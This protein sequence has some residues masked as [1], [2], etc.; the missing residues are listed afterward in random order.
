MKKK[1]IYLLFLFLSLVIFGLNNTLQA[2]T[3]FNPYIGYGVTKLKDPLTAL[4]IYGGP[5]PSEG[6]I[7]SKDAKLYCIIRSNLC[8]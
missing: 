4:E 3:F 1:K 6:P 2:Q 7:I 8:H 5:R